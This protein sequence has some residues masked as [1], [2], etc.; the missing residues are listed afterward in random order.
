MNN[1]SAAEVVAKVRTS[2]SRVLFAKVYG[3][4]ALN[5]ASADETFDLI[6]RA[7]AAY[8]T[9]REVNAFSSKFDA[10]LAGRATLTERESRGLALFAG[11]ANCTA[12]HPHQPSAD[13]TPPLF[14]DY[15]FDNVGAPWNV[16]NPFYRA[17]VAVNPEG[18]KYRDLGLGAALKDAAHH[19]KVKVPT[20]RNVAK[21]PHPQFVKSYLHNGTFK[22]LQDVV[23][24]YNRRDKSPADFAPPDVE[25][26]VNHEELGNLGLTAAEE[27]DVVAFL[28][29]LSDGH[30]ASLPTASPP[31][32]SQPEF[33]AT[34]PPVA[35]RDRFRGIREVLR[36]ERFRHDIL[37]EASRDR[38][39]RRR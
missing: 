36:V 38:A 34:A 13:G 15:S 28:E 39:V 24:F 10:Y 32:A 20:L 19:G 16:G 23:R 35:S 14:T 5:E 37:E 21:R 22:N 17:D 4:Q 27:D 6:G 30:V 1:A 9:S 25:E 18:A 11:K 26:N 7:I 12:C 31:T 33:P 29:T 3:P 2:D 8:E